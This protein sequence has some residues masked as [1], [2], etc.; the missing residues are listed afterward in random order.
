MDKI[1]DRLG[2]Y[3]L[4]G[5]FIPG[6]IGWLSTKFLFSYLGIN[7]GNELGDMNNL[8]IVLVGSYLLGSILH[9]WGHIVSKKI[10]YRKEKEPFYNYLSLDNDL[11]RPYEKNICEKLLRKVLGIT[12]DLEYDQTRY[13]FD[14][15]YE[16]LS[17]WGKSAKADTFES[18]Y[19]M[20]RSLCCFYLIL[21][22]GIICLYPVLKSKDMIILGERFVFSVI[23]SLVLAK[24]FQS[25]ARRFNKS[26]LKVVLRT[27]IGLQVKKIDD[28]QVKNL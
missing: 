1:L 11:L 19:G 6:F 5:I 2:I 12:G 28:L 8:P 3:D 23:A 22:G 16:L 9:E 14:Y 4:W 10:I 7:F 20:S 15:C 18:L 25:R 26:R 21:S 13:F 27:F 17:V 24:V